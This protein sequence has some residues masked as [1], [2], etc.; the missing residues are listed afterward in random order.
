[1]ISWGRKAARAGAP[2]DSDSI[3]G[4]RVTGLLDSVRMHLYLIFFP[5]YKTVCIVVVQLF[6]TRIMLYSNGLKL[7]LVTDT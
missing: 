3:Y 4:K 1:M 2:P 5:T 7:H 6:T